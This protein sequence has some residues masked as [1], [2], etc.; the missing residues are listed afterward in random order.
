LLVAVVLAG[1]LAVVEAP[2]DAQRSVVGKPAIFGDEVTVQ[3]LAC[4]V[5]TTSLTVPPADGRLVGVAVTE[6]TAG[7]TVAALATAAIASR[8]AARSAERSIP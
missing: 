1:T 8:T 4:L 7:L 5:L 6:T 2:P 3:V